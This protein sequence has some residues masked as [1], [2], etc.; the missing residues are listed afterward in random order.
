MSR[1]HL[2][3]RRRKPKPAAQ[4]PVVPIVDYLQTAPA[5]IEIDSSA[6]RAIRIAPDTRGVTLADLKRQGVETYIPMETGQRAHHGRVERVEY[7]RPAFGPSYAFCR[8]EDGRAKSVVMQAEGVR[9]L[10]HDRHEPVLDR[11]IAELRRRE[12]AGEFAAP[13]K[14]GAD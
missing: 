1:T 7:Q 8:I 11:E 3:H 12:G 9:V 10:G 5:R 4:A 6:W 2:G 13:P 14:R